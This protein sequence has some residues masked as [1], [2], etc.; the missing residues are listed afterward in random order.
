M[1]GWHIRYL[2]I[3]KFNLHKQVA[4][5]L[6]CGIIAS[7]LYYSM[8]LWYSMIWYDMIWLLRDCHVKLL[9]HLFS[10]IYDNVFFTNLLDEYIESKTLNFF[11]KNNYRKTTCNHL[12]SF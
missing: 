1:K 11:E 2:I 5:R 6:P 7:S 8:T 4:K 3:N 10:I 12:N 9:L